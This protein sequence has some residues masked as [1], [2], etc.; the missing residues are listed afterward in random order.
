MT[1]CC[2]WKEIKAVGCRGIYTD[3]DIVNCHPVLL[4]QL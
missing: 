4:Q 2:M 1:Q 3:I